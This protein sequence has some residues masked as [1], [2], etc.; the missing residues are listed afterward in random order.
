M[1]AQYNK[2]PNI[3]DYRFEKRTWGNN[4]EL[5]HKLDEEGHRWQIAIRSDKKP[6]KGDILILGLSPSDRRTYK[7]VSVRACRDPSDMFFVET[8]FVP[9]SKISG[10][11]FFQDFLKSINWNNGKK[12]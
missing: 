11:K 1:A 10:K 4:F 12:S 9:G 3:F 6:I 2:T 5:S 7:I 8:K